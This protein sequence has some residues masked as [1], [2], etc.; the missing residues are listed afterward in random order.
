M[1]FDDAIRSM[2]REEIRAAMRDELR[3]LLPELRDSSA[4]DEFLSVREAAQLARVSP[5]T[6]RA[7]L[8]RAELKRFGTVRLPRIRRA[9]LI[10]FMASQAP[11]ETEQPRT[12]E[13]QAESILSRQDHSPPRAAERE[14][15]TPAPPP[16]RAAPARLHSPQLDDELSD[17]TR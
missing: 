5:A 13:E 4:P 1:P 6:V 16:R 9:D 7:W 15:S 17:G 3:A 11:R 10:R 12:I 14:H 8:R 2:L